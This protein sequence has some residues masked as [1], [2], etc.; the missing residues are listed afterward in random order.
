MPAKH[1][2]WLNQPY[3]LSELVSWPAGLLL[4]P[5]SQHCQGHPL[6]SI[7]P[8][9]FLHFAFGDAQL[10]PQHHDFQVFVGFGHPAYLY[11]RNECGKNLR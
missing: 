11:K 8:H 6:G 5:T 10:I 7:G 1:C 2:L 4:Q 9:R 3:Q